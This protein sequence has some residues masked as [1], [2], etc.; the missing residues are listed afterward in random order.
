M[1][2]SLYHS[3]G[4]VD[5]RCYQ[6]VKEGQLIYRSGDES[7]EDDSVDSSTIPKTKKST[8][9]LNLK[10]AWPDKKL[11][12]TVAK[13]KTA[14]QICNEKIAVVKLKDK[15]KYETLKLAR[16]KDKASYKQQLEKVKLKELV[17][18]N[19]RYL[20]ENMSNYMISTIS[21]QWPGVSQEWWFTEFKWY[22]Q[23]LENLIRSGYI[24]TYK[25][26]ASS[27]YKYT[28]NFKQYVNSQEETSLLDML[29]PWVWDYVYWL[30]LY[31]TNDK[32]VNALLR[33]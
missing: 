13:E 26:F 33:L 7:Q 20:Y 22:A 4:L 32:I 1:C 29:L 5:R 28:N 2:V 9:K 30:S 14:T 23:Q 15:Q 27:T 18:R 11:Q 16:S 19:N 31:D 17:A 12:T 10:E 3:L 21:T 8:L 25:D 6:K 24:Y